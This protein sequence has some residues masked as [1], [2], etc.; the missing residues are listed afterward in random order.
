[1]ADQA[2]ALRHLLEQRESRCRSVAVVSGK[3][4]VGKSSFTVSFAVSLAK[5]GQRVLVIDLDIGMGNVQ[6]LAGSHTATGIKQ[7]LD[8]EAALKETIMAGPAGIS[9]IAGGSGLERIMEWDI[10]AFQRLLEAFEEFQHTYSVILFDMGAG[11]AADTL[12]VL[13]SAEEVFV[14]TVP[15]PTAVMDAYSMMKFISLKGFGGKISL[16][17]N[18]SE[19]D[20]EGKLTVDR[21]TAAMKKFMGV[22]IGLLGIIPEDASVKKAVKLQQPLVLA[23]PQSEAAKAISRMAGTFM[24]G[25]SAAAPA[26]VAEKLKTLFRIGRV[27]LS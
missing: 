8:G 13:M 7:Y 3:G 25:Q 9:Y 22:D 16:I 2:S 18:R 26:T 17:C 4:G 1:M 27:R 12:E 23:Y 19:T 24:T 14:V 21:L 20:G 15:E 10:K 5:Q 6:I 11:A